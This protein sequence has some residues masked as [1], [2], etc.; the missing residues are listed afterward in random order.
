MNRD[1]NALDPLPKLGSKLQTEV[2]FF[3]PEER[4]IKPFLYEKDG[5]LRYAPPEPPH[6]L[7]TSQYDID[8]CLEEMMRDIGTPA[9]EEEKQDNKPEFCSLKSGDIIRCHE[10]LEWKLTEQTNFLGKP[11]WA[12]RTKDNMPGILCESDEFTMVERA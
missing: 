9:V 8:V 11:A 7:E 6:R 2:I 4:E 1:L 3:H 12:C 5:K 10:G